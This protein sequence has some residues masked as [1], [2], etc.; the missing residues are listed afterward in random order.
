[1][2]NLQRF[3]N[4]KIYKAFIGTYNGKINVVDGMEDLML[5]SRI[6][7]DCPGLLSRLAVR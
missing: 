2:K 1:M 6:K 7:A 4:S 3:K 5:W